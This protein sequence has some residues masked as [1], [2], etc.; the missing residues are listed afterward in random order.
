MLD[1][2]YVNGL[3][4]G[5]TNEAGYCIALSAYAENT[6]I[7]VIIMNCISTS[8]RTS[9]AKTLLSCAFGWY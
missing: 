4:T 6:D 5:C 1:Y 8:T 9:D 7:V 3:K 2:S